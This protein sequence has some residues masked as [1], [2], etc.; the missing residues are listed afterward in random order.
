MTRVSLLQ[1]FPAF[2]ERSTI[3]E[4]V[5]NDAHRKRK[6]ADIKETTNTNIF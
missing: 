6:H 4:F 5:T 3:S 1:W 2:P